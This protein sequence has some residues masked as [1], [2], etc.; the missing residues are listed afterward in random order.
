MVM[1]FLVI[2]LIL[3]VP[4]VFSLLVAPEAFATDPI[5][6]RASV[7]DGD[8]LEI[9]GKRIRLHGID[10]PE[11]GQSCLVGSRK[12]RCGQWASQALSDKIMR[13][14]VS[15]TPRD[16]DR[17][18]RVVAVCRFRGMDLN[19]WMVS[20][21]WALAYRLY[22]RDYIRQENRASNSQVGVW[23]GKFVKPWDWRRGKRL[24]VT[25]G[26][27]RGRCIIKGNISRRGHIYHVPGDKYYSRTKI[28]TSKGE[29][30]FCSEV[31]ARAAGWRRSWR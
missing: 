11:N 12:Y 5:I 21:G 4:A 29:R 17:Y 26:K 8:T 14:T 28:T 31:E 9:H 2:V 3:L 15:C 30:W 23:Q 24:T 25:K 22:S 18:G 19:A 7:I 1:K 16:S 13:G 6:G 20:K 10:A 27:E